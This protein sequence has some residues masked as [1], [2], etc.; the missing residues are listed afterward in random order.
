MLLTY[1]GSKGLEWP[2]VIMP[3]LNEGNTPHSK[4]MQQDEIE[5]ERRMFYV[6]VTRAKIELYLFWSLSN[7]GNPIYPSRYLNKI[8]EKKNE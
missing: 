8:I 1:H 4:A 2:C 5:E 3:F 6:A 7:H